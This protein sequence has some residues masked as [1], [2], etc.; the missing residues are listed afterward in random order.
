MVT[1]IILKTFQFWELN[2]CVYKWFVKLLKQ[3]LLVMFINYLW[4]YFKT[5]LL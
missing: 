1:D 2:S 4:N 5:L 3:L